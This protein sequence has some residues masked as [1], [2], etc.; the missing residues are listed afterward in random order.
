MDM[1]NNYSK[2]DE[3][4]DKFKGAL[5]K[6]RSLMFLMSKRDRMFY[7]RTVENIEYRFRT[8]TSVDIINNYFGNDPLCEKILDMG[9]SEINS[10]VENS[11]LDNVPTSIDALNQV[12]VLT[13]ERLKMGRVNNC[14]N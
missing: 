4:I 12:D 6:F 10:I 14:H 8:D 5:K 11:Q 2:P 1:Y 13:V 3:F 9:I 7:K